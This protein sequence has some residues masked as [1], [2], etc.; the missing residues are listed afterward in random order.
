MN[1]YDI[2]RVIQI[3]YY[4]V[5]LFIKFRGSIHVTDD[6]DSILTAVTLDAL[7]IEH[8]KFCITGSPLTYASERLRDD[9]YIVSK[10]IINLTALEYVSDRL[11]DDYTIATIAVKIRDM[12]PLCIK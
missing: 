8:Y 12:P 4:A 3:A 1:L 7:Y 6:Y 10:A 9:Y 11:R 5:K 2:F